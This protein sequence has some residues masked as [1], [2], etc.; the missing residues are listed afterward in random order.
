MLPPRIEIEFSLWRCA[1][2]EKLRFHPQMTK[3]TMSRTT[4]AP[5]RA[6]LSICQSPAPVC[7]R[8]RIA[9]RVCVLPRLS[10]V[11]PFTSGLA[12]SVLSAAASLM[13]RQ[14]RPVAIQR[15]PS[16]A[17]DKLS[18]EPI[19]CRYSANDLAALDGFAGLASQPALVSKSSAPWTASHSQQ[20]IAGPSCPATLT[21]GEIVPWPTSSTISTYGD[22]QYCGREGSGTSRCA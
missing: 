16:C 8:D 21:Y 2:R 20:S 19:S 11:V 4:S 3:R 1:G 9:Q 18:A 12:G 10:D 7:T 13:P 14:P 5:H 22:C 17:A 6:S 15:A